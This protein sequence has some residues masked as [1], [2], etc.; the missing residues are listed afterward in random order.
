MIGQPRSFQAIPSCL[1]F[2]DTLYNG[3]MY[4]IIPVRNRFLLADVV[5]QI[6]FPKIVLQ[7]GPSQW[8]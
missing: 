5:F 8:N 1:T 6:Q 4:P 3:Q 7:G 2:V